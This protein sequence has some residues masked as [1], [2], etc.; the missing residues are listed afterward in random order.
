LW[1]VA[2]FEAREMASLLHKNVIEAASFAR[3]FPRISRGFEEAPGVGR[4]ATDLRP[5]LANESVEDINKGGTMFLIKYDGKATAV[6]NTFDSAASYVD[7]IRQPGHRITIVA[8]RSDD[9]SDTLRALE[10]RDVVA[11]NEHV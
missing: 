9:W 7:R 8:M 2:I 10:R 5:T 3:A 1:S 4:G 6:T 11:P